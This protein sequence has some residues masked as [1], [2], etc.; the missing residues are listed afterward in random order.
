MMIAPATGRTKLHL[1]TSDWR[2][3]MQEK[4]QEKTDY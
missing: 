3:P 1:N 2:F 4:A